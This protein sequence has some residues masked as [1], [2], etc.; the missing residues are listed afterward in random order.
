MQLKHA[1]GVCLMALVLVQVSEAC[2]WRAGRHCCF[3]RKSR[4]TAVVEGA[5]EQMTAQETELLSKLKDSLVEKYPDARLTRL[6]IDGN[7]VRLVGSAPGVDVAQFEQDILT[8]FTNEGWDYTPDLGGVEGVGEPSDA[9]EGP[10]VVAP[11]EVPEVTEVGATGGFR[12]W[13]D[14]SGRKTGANWALV[15]MTDTA[16]RL[17]REGTK[18]ECDVLISRLSEE[19]R[20]YLAAIVPE[21]TREF[22][23]WTNNIGQEVQLVTDLLSETA[24]NFVAS[25]GGNSSNVA[26]ASALAVAEN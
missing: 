2:G 20:A 13:T 19:D 7:I 16:V 10:D 5:Q 26:P 1:A 6:K 11:P 25:F 24:R 3:L 23:S 21:S 12:G 9:T 17:R 15:G 14:I 8:I 4:G 22:R 18:E